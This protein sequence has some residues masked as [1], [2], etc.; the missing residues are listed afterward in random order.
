MLIYQK[1]GRRQLLA[2]WELTLATRASL[3]FQEAHST[4]PRDLPHWT[5]PASRAPSPTE[6]L[7]NTSSS[8]RLRLGHFLYESFLTFRRPAPNPWCPLVVTEFSLI[9]PTAGECFCWLFPRRQKVPS[10][11]NRVSFTQGSLL[12]CLLPSS[13]G[14]LK[15]KNKQKNLKHTNGWTNVWM[16]QEVHI[17]PPQEENQIKVPF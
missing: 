5:A 17:S 1:S 12:N 9:M 11:C 7:P 13:L 14:V 16:N 15:N 3:W 6:N 4:R 2:I 10:V 8:P